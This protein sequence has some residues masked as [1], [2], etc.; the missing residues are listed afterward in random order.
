M[1]TLLGKFYYFEFSR[2][3]WGRFWTCAWSVFGTCGRNRLFKSINNVPS[4]KDWQHKLIGVNKDSFCNK[5]TVLD[6][7]QT[8]IST[9]VKRSNTCTS[10]FTPTWLNTQVQSFI[11]CSLYESINTFFILQRYQANT[12]LH[13]KKKV[14]E[15][16]KCIG[17]IKKVH[18]RLTIIDW[19]I[20]QYYSFFL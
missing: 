7:W 14:F 8:T 6:H 20:S 12:K 10:T 9:G 3:F 18:T 11:K 15:N 16:L 5:W 1:V 17:T 13:S 19:L 2:G 4:L